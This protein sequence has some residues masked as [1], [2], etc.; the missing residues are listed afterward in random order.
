MNLQNTPPTEISQSQKTNMILSYLYEV[1]SQNHEDPVERWLPEA[2]KRQ[3][4]KLAL[5]ENRVS[6]LQNEKSSGNGPRWL[7]AQRECYFM[8]LTCTLKMIKIVTLMCI[9]P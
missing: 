9:S 3:S 8:P 2:G 7:V 1:L 6:V 5:N 4:G